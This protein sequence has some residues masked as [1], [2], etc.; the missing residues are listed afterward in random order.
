[1]REKRLLKEGKIGRADVYVFKMSDCRKIIE[2]L[3]KGKA[4][5]FSGC[6]GCKVKPGLQLGAKKVE[7]DWDGEK[8]MVKDSSS[9][10]VGEWL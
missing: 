8:E 2:R 9:A 3:Q 6:K 4:K 1:M 7:S 10:F 5:G